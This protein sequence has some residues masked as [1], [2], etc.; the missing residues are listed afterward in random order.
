M[1][2]SIEIKGESLS[3][4]PEKAI[5][6]EKESALLLADLHLGKA[7]HFRKE[8]IAVPSG[9]AD[10]NY[11]KLYQLFETYP[12][13]NV[14]FLGDLFHSE[15]NQEWVRVTEIVNHFHQTAFHLVLGNHDILDNEKYQNAGLNIVG[16]KKDIRG[17]R[18]EHE[19]PETATK[20]FTLC[21][22]IHPGVMI[23]GRGR[24]NLRLPCF[25]FTENFMILPAF[26]TFTGVKT[27][28][29]SDVNKA[30]AVVGD[31]IISI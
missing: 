6:W 15:Y 14:Y 28:K 7:Q 23:K 16:T 12:T 26:G 1:S 17:I 3:L 5:Y 18:L 25:Y 19:P 13:Q 10:D 20:Q 8:G 11:K 9:V 4:L 29:V 24:Q 21:G 30:F 31:K 22:H 27:L 2:H